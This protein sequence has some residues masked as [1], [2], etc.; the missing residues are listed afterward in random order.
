MKRKLLFAVG[1]IVTATAV[2][3]TTNDVIESIGNDIESGFNN[4]RGIYIDLRIQYTDPVNTG[5]NLNKSPIAIPPVYIEDHT[6]H[7][8]SYPFEEISLIATDEDGEEAIVYSTAIL[9]ETETIEIPHDITG[10]YEIC[11]TYGNYCF[12]GDIVL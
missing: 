6:L 7:I 8:G 10:E 2:G 3:N 11:L 12:Y 9:S 1:L 5:G 4:Y